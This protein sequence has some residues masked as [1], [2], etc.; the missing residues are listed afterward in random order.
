[1]KTITYVFVDKHKETIEVDDSVA[2][3]YEEL[4]RYEKKVNR[5]ET[6][7]HMSLEKC[8]KMVSISPILP[9]I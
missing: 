2:E 4:L 8:W 7:R 3:V 6:R 1:M 5:K 9:Q